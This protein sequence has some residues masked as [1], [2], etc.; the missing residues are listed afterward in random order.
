MKVRNT[1]MV[2]EDI[3]LNDQAVYDVTVKRLQQLLGNGEY[4]RTENG[5]VVVKQDDPGWRHGSVG[6]EY[7]RDATELDI[8]IF[9]VLNTL[10]AER[11]VAINRTR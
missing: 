4:L 8:A 11:Q 2:Y 10:H 9:K 5:K 1:R 7:V 6:E 3:D